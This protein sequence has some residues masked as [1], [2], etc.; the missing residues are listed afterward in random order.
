MTTS[1]LQAIFS[2]RGLVDPSW[3]RPEPESRE[4]TAPWYVQAMVGFGAWLAGIL[5]IVFLAIVTMNNGREHWQTPM[6]LGVL[7][8]VIS[9]IL[10]ATVAAKSLFVNQIA[11]A[12]SFGGQIG[13]AV[14][15]GMSDGRAKALLWGMFLVEIAL[16]FAVNNRFNR[17]LSTLAAVVFWAFAV[18]ELLLKD[19]WAFSL[20]S[21][22]SAQ[23]PDVPLSLAL[24]LLVWTPVIVGALWL[25]KNE[26]TWMAQG[27]EA[28]L[29]PVVNGL[30]AAL[31][32]APLALLP[33]V[34]WLAL[35]LRASSSFSAANSLVAPWPLFGSVL[36]LFSLALAFTFRNR[37]LMGLAVIFALFEIS[38][39]Y[40]VFEVSLL[41]KSL[42]MIL[43]GAIL[44]A[45]ARLLQAAWR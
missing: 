42:I 4:Q 40:Y 16:V 31:A 27:K 2:E 34:F 24:W 44:L 26:S 19:S 10:F 45:S 28:I 43:L 32:I 41:M 17:F 33:N 1:E 20:K 6:I 8:C 25:A 21:S 38:S 12:L 9:G 30:I 37:P 11:L 22:Q 3:H 23:G 18:D 13:I 35:D 39:F 29:R 7:L 15:L 36:G 14:G 5:L